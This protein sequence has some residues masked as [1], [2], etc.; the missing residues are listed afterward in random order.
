MATIQDIAAALRSLAKPGMKPKALRAAI[1]ERFPDATKKEI[2]RAA[3]YAVTDEPSTSEL[4]HFALVERVA[5][6]NEGEVLRVNKR[7]K[8]K[9]AADGRDTPPVH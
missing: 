9:R 3:F 1:R 2:V 8:K 6:D 7:G 4:H 5:E